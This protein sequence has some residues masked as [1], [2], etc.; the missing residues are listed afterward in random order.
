VTWMDE[1]VERDA[2]QCSVFVACE[3][4]IVREAIL[5]RF[6]I[7]VSTSSWKGLLRVTYVHF[8]TNCFLDCS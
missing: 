1:F 4:G 3:L 5:Y 8:Q 7:P 6:N 2:P